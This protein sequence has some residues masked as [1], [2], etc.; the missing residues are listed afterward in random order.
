MAEKEA[1]TEGESTELGMNS[2]AMIEENAKNKTVIRYGDRVP[3]EIIVD[4]RHYK[5]GQLIEP[6]KVMADQL[7]KDKIAKKVY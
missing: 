4:T 5:K 3:C 1:K 6:H 2:K 7:I